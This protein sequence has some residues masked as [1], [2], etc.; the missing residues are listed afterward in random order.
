MTTNIKVTD[1]SKKI[2]KITEEENK[3]HAKFLKSEL[4]KIFTNS[5]FVGKAFQSQLF[6]NF[7]SGKPASFIR[8]INIFS[9]L[10]YISTCKSHNNIFSNSAF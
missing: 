8:L 6:S 3:L 9:S 7:N 4:K 1:Y 2:I 5:I 10:G